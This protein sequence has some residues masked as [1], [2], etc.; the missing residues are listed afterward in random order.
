MHRLR[1]LRWT[2]PQ[3]DAQLQEFDTP[4]FGARPLAGPPGLQRAW[5]RSRSGRSGKARH[6]PVPHAHG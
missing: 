6:R 3:E 4:L 5:R 2:H 1:V